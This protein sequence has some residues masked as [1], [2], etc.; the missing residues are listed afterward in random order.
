MTINIRDFVIKMGFDATEVDRGI[1]QIESRLGRVGDR[2]L[3]QSRQQL[4]LDRSQA[5]LRRDQ[6]SMTRQSATQRE[7][8]VSAAQRVAQAEA[9]TANA[10]RRRRAEESRASAQRRRDEAL[11]RAR[12]SV[13]AAAGRGRISSNERLRDPANNDIRNQRTRLQND[14]NDIGRRAAGATNAN[15]IARLRRELAALTQQASLTAGANSRLTRSMRQQRFAS[16]S[17]RN[18]LQNLGRSYLSVFAIIGGGAAALRTGQDLVQV[19][20][21]LLA[22]SGDA[23]TAASNFAFLRDEALRL[24]TDITQTTRGFQQFGVAARAAGLPT[25]EIRSLFTQ[26]TEAGVAFGLSTDDQSGIFRAFSQTISRGV[27]SMEELN[28]NYYH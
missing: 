18:S 10:A 21:S 3:S 6:L 12:L 1:R 16:N 5:T 9:R 28:D 27:V 22:A 19:Q 11:Q 8:E 17:L 20:A 23:T 24:G 25:E 15:D 13:Q 2:R 4:R 7:R 14:F 26:V